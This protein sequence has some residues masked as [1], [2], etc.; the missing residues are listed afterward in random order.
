M[1]DKV[2]QAVVSKLFSGRGPLKRSPQVPSMKI[3]FAFV[4]SFYYRECIK[5][6]TK[7]FIHGVIV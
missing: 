1:D 7:M 2:F 6:M 5:H 4:C 3:F